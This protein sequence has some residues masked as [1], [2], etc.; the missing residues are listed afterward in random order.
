MAFFPA[1]SHSTWRVPIEVRKLAGYRP[2]MPLPFGFAL[3]GWNKLAPTKIQSAGIGAGASSTSA[4][5][6]MA[7]GCDNIGAP[8]A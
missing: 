7:M 1:G 8:N 6:T 2:A 4:G 3:R 5:R